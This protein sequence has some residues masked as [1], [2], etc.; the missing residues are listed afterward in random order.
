MNVASNWIPLRPTLALGALGFALLGAPAL[1]E[2]PTADEI[3]ACVRANLPSRSSIQ[4]VAF[5]VNGRAGQ[6]TSSHVKIHWQQSEEQ[7]SKVLL[8]FDAPPDMR[9]SALLLIEKPKRNDMFMYL[10]ELRRVRRVT[11]PALS[12]GMFGTD[13]TYSQFE[14]LQGVARDL[15]VERL[16]DEQLDGKTMHV[17]GHEPAD[18]PEFEYVKSYVEPERCVPMKTEFFESGKRLR[19]VLTS[20]PEQ[21]KAVGKN[22]IPHRMVMADVVQGTSTEFE[23]EAID[24]EA[25]IH[26]KTFTEAYLAQGN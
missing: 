22:W 10:P 13:F 4:T 6:T 18:D 21:V 16:P 26:R 17:L 25:K 5:R 7:L 12:G 20:D 11:G 14:R 8:R 19:K 9:G 24:V 23:V 15:S 3:E 1:A 2:G